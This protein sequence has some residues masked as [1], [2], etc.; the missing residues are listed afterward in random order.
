M[1]S[2]DV[3]SVPPRIDV[4]SLWITP[5]QRKKH[6]P[7]RFD[8]TREL[9]NSRHS[10]IDHSRCQRVSA[11]PECKSAFA[12]DFFEIQKTPMT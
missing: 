10:L 1:M 5:A 3:G 6:L 4:H 8:G 12:R 9:E 2:G 7:H 11:L